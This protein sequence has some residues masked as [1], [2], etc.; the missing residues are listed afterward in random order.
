M[1][2]SFTT[3]M[4]GQVLLLGVLGSL[5]AQTPSRVGNDVYW[6][7]GLAGDAI[8]L[9][10]DLNEAAWGQAEVI[11]I[12]YGER[13]ALPTSGWRAEFQEDAYF[14][15][16]DAT[17]RMLVD[18]TNNQLYLAVEAQDSSVGGIGSWARWDGLL[19]SIKDHN[20]RSSVKTTEPREFFYTFWYVNV[21]SLIAPGVPPRFIGSFGNFGD[22]I[23]TA[24]QR[25]VWDAKFKMINGITNDDTTPDEGYI[26]E[27]R[28]NLDS[29]GYDA[30]SSA[31]DIVELNFSIW[32]GDWLHA[33]DPSKIAVSRTSWQSPWNGNND[34]VGRV[35]VRPDVT[36]NSGALPDV[37]PDIYV[38]NGMTRTAPVID[39]VLDEE[40]WDYAY[41]FDITFDDSLLRESYPGVGK[42][43]SGQF[44]PEVGGNPR[45]PVLDPGTG[46][47]KMF[48]RD[49]NLYLAADVTD[50][51]VQ[52]TSIENQ[53]DAV[54][55]LFMHRDSVNADNEFEF[56]KFTAS[57]DSSTM[58]VPT[59]VLPV[60]I[61]DGNAEFAYTLKGATTVNNHTDIDEGYIVEMRIDLTA[62]GYASGLGDHLLF[63]GVC[64]FDGDS[65]DDPLSDYGSRTWWFRENNWG[66]STPWMVMDESLTGIGDSDPAHLPTRVELYGNYPNPFNPTTTISYALPFSGDVELLVYNLLGQKVFS[67]KLA[68]VT[69]GTR[70]MQ[71]DANSLAS[72]VYFY[73]VQATNPQ[74]GKIFRSQ[75]AKMVFLK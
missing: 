14:D 36:I 71:F 34:N 58:M 30:T 8:T 18:N 13:S 33:G 65:F 10:G 67:Q 37:D 21:D 29:L 45:P 7:R 6:A 31:G 56:F 5:W 51:V 59:E 50:G 12:K 57:F 60:F 73:R 68:K 20:V 66:Q 52:G 23:R 55:F 39:G 3:L 28:I 25:T 49:D 43:R 2:R 35:Y 46:N 24:Q 11:T 62:L 53:W 70:T 48:F 69:A 40:M 4:L 15:H 42:W 17:V 22:T 72:G 9:D 38:P 54:R 1:S 41:S 32:D 61:T 19:M 26:M 47:I 16:T 27:M 64:L 74:T 63:G 44:Q 75:T